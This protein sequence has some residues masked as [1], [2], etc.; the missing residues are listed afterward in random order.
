MRSLN[1]PLLVVLLLGLAA[2]SSPQ[3]TAPAA[4]GSRHT[5]RASVVALP[6]ADSMLHLHHEA[7]DDFP[8]QDGKPM[9]MDSM[10]MPFPVTKDLPLDGIAVGDRV[11]VTL[12]VDW[13]ADS[14]VQV[15]EVKELPADA[16][17]LVFGEAKPAGSP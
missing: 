12:L 4:G 5:V 15:V 10:T 3:E 17:P 7:I 16:P 6:G 11:E 9:G 14:S 8:G 2:C 13:K 1:A